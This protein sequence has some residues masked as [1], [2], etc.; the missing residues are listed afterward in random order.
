MGV[1]NKLAHNGWLILT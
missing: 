1:D